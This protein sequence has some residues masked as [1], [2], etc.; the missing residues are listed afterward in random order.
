MESGS[1][2]DVI[3]KLDN[4]LNEFF[5]KFEGKGIDG[6][7]IYVTGTHMVFNENEN[8]YIEVKKHPEAVLTSE[9]ANWFSCLITD[10]NKIQIGQKKFWD[11]EDDILKM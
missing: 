7:D 2:V 1:R 10:D 8:K 5:Y 6:S 9:T 11:W 3:M 4:K